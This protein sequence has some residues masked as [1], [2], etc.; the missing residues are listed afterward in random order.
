M[1]EQPIDLQ[2]AQPRKAGFGPKFWNV[3]A[4]VVASPENATRKR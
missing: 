2:Q 3:D 1:H 4:K